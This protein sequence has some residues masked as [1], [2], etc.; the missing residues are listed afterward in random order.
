[1]TGGIAIRLT[2]NPSGAEVDIDGV[3]WG[4]T[5]TAPLTRLTAGAH[6]ISVRKIGYQHWDRK[7]E[8]AAGDDRTVNAELELDPT[9]PHIAGLD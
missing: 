2:S 9:K 5:P 7:I 1:M 8:L 6:T 4:T 3:Y